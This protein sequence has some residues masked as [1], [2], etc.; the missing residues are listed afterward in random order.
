MD[1]ERA[2]E[3]VELDTAFDNEIEMIPTEQSKSGVE[4]FDP[5]EMVTIVE[6]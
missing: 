5:N 2:D 6:L 3:L 4:S 1:L